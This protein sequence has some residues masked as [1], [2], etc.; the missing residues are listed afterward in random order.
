MYS[1]STVIDKNGMTIFSKSCGSWK[2]SFV[3]ISVDEPKEGQY[4]SSPAIKGVW[5]REEGGGGNPTY[6]FQTEETFHFGEKN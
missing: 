2:K 1:L 5:G 3:S 6:E 4:K